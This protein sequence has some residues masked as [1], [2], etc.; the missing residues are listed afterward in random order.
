MHIAQQNR[1]YYTTPCFFA[2]FGSKFLRFICIDFWITTQ[3]NPLLLWILHI[4]QLDTHHN[5]ILKIVI[6]I[7]PVYKQYSISPVFKQYSSD[8]GLVYG[9]D[10][11]HKGYNHIVNVWEHFLITDKASD[12]VA[13]FLYDLDYSSGIIHQWTVFLHMYYTSLVQCSTM[14]ILNLLIYYSWLRYE[15]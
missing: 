9:V 12:K 10:H 15:G 3:H 14:L 5:A 6:F 1:P 2:T 8:Y 13:S 11:H 7:S 4:I